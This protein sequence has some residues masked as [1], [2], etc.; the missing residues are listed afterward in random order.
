MAGYLYFYSR[1]DFFH[2][3]RHIYYS[4]SRRAGD[5]SPTGACMEEII[6]RI[7]QAEKN[8]EK[9]LEDARTS[10][11]ALRARVEQESAG[12]L[13]KARLEGK[14]RY[15]QKVADAREK[16]KRGFDEAI[17]DAERRSREFQARNGDRLESIAEKVVE[18]VVTPEYDRTAGGGTGGRISGSTG[19]GASG[20]APK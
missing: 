2:R 8:A 15:E 4:S 19:A 1:I 16:G 6:E 12:K 18:L 7:V 5:I 20:K 17:Q 9:L 10:E 14:R 13:E 11:S 3:N